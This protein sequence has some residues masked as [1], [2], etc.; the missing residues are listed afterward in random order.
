MNERPKKNGH[1]TKAMTIVSLSL[2]APAELQIRF[3]CFSYADRRVR[4]GPAR[5]PSASG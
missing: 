1:G 3:T 4:R 2:Q 5:H